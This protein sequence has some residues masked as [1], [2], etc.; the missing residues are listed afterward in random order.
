[1]VLCTLCDTAQPQENFYSS[2]LNRNGL[3]GRCKSCEKTQSK[4]YQESNR[5]TVLQIKAN[6][7]ATHKEEIREKARIYRKRHH[8]DIQLSDKL[9][10]Q[11]HKEKIN[12]SR[13]A[14]AAYNKERRSAYGATTRARRFGVTVI[15][16]VCL[17]TLYERDQGICQICQQP[18]SQED[19]SRDHQESSGEP[20]RS[21]GGGIGG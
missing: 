13:H 15:E 10:F 3:S 7:R 11:R 6:Y 18:C 5:S 1:M 17:P 2:R 9:Y 20:P 8:E 19:A 4:K 14:R 21:G 12:Q 16:L